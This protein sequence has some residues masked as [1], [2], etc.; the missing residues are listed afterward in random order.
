LSRSC[1]SAP[2]PALVTKLGSSIGAQNRQHYEVSPSGE[3]YAIVKFIRPRA[4]YFGSPSDET[5]KGHPLADRGLGPYGVFEIRKSSWV[6]ALARFK[7]RLDPAI[8]VRSWN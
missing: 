1:A 2:N 7:H 5:L 3:H 8:K 4:H 6:R